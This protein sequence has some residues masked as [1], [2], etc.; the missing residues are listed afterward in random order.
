[1]IITHNEKVSSNFRGTIIDLETI[2]DFSRQFADNDSRQY[3][4]LKPAIL[5]Y[6]TKNE[7]N[8]LCAKGEDAIDEL[9]ER[10]VE[11]V[12]SLKAPLFAFQSRFERGVFH[13]SCGM[14]IEFDGELN[15]EI[16]E[17]KGNACTELDIP[18]YGD[19]FNNV[20][21]ECNLAWERGDYEKAIKHNRSCL[22]KERDILLKRTYREPDELKLV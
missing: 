16:F 18:N 12:P 1:M 3:R 13:H 9:I 15:K 10:S 14:Q 17:W 7:L 19:P 5:G 6:I 8:I 11:I 22:L 20:G 2:G 4:T 21:R